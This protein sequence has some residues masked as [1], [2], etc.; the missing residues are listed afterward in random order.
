MRRFRTPDGRRPRWLRGPDL[1][2]LRD[3]EWR[4]PRWPRWLVV[5]AFERLRMADFDVPKH[6]LLPG[7]A[8]ILLLFGGGLYFGNM[9]GSDPSAA[10]LITTVKVKGKVVTL[11]G[12]SVKVVVPPRTITRH[13][14]R[15]KLPRSTVDVTKTQTQTQIQTRQHTV[16]VPVPTTVTRTTTIRVPTTIV[17]TVTTTV[18][19]TVP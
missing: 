5:P 19:T 16:I 1:D 14:K 6:L 11:K 10:T 15:V 18:T 17:S 4:G 9:L 13:G 2:R 8:A 12:K 7:I 3:R